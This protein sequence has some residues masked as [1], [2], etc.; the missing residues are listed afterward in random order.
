MVATSFK[1]AVLCHLFYPDGQDKLFGKL[2]LLKALD[3]K[4]Y[5]NIVDVGTDR[6]P[7]IQRIRASFPGSVLIQTPHKGRDIGGKLSLLNVYFNTGD[8]RELLLFIHDK[9]SPHISNASFWVDELLRIVDK[10]QLNKVMG[11]FAA[12]EQCGIVCAQKFIQNEYDP[13][14]KSFNC[15]SSE[16]LK[17]MI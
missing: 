16:I 4:F 10:S 17:D 9:Q 5:F 11:L 15:T 13:R 8:R 1:I 14:S 12:D 7:L 6:G 3:T 2:S